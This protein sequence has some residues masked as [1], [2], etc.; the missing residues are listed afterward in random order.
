MP[1]ADVPAPAELVAERFAVELPPHAH[2][3]GPDSM[4]AAAVAPAADRVP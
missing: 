1:A 4:F 2:S 3:A